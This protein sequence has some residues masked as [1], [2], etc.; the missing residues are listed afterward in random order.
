MAYEGEELSADAIL[1]IASGFRTAKVLASAV[2]LGLFTLLDDGPKTATELCAT[3]G[4]HER[5]GRHFLSALNGLGMLRLTDGRYENTALAGRYLTP[6]AGAGLDAFVGFLDHDLAPA[7]TGLTEALRAGRRPDRAG[8]PYLEQYDD[9]A[10]RERFLAAMDWLN[11][12]ISAELAK[13]D[14]HE[15]TSFVDVGGARG[16]AAAHLVREHPHLRGIVFE[17]P[18]VWPEFD[19]HMRRLGLAGTVEFEGGDFFADALP[20]ADVVVFGHVLHNWGDEE[21]NLLLGKAN[22]ALPP[23]GKVIVYDPMIDEAD[24]RIAAAIASLN[25]LVWSA[26]GSEYSRDECRAMLTGHGFDV[27]SVFEAGPVDTVVV[28]RKRG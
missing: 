21:R 16:N 3:L 25:M 20:K 23:G 7:W 19:G 9:P 6:R 28:A 13:L 24:G 26:G 18:E 4:L 2:E 22:D 15:V 5:A 17:R 14:W 27:E 10:G 1:K 8:D 11:A 12:P